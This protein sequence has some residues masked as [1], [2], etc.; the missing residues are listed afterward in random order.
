MCAHEDVA[1][2]IRLRVILR[3]ASAARVR[4]CIA[5]AVLII[6]RIEQGDRVG[7]DEG[8]VKESRIRV[9]KLEEERLDDC[10]RRDLGATLSEFPEAAPLRDPV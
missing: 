5:V 9:E 2:G 6:E 1:I 8:D 3:A 7:L 4:V 10:R